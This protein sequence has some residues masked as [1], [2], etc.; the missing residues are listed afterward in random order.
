MYIRK[1]LRASYTE[2][3]SVVSGVKRDLAFD[4]TNSEIASTHVIIHC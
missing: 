3:S 2:C 1:A 4:K